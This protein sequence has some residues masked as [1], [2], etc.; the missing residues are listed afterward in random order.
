LTTVNDILTV[1][2]KE[3]E[4]CSTMKITSIAIKTS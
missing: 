4:R 1:V 3:N 2:R